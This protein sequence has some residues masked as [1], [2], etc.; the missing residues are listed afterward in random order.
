MF[1]YDW[2]PSRHV[3][4]RGGPLMVAILSKTCN[5]D[6]YRIKNIIRK[7]LFKFTELNFSLQFIL[8]ET[9][10]I[11]HQSNQNLVHLFVE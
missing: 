1:I 4:L 2:P 6:K 11:V 7:S 9:R 5:V 8:Y 3:F 10:A